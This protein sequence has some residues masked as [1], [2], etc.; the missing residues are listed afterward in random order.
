MF[1]VLDLTADCD[2]ERQ[3][4]EREATSKETIIEISDEEEDDDDDDNDDDVI[5]LTNSSPSRNNLASQVA[6]LDS[7]PATSQLPMIE[8]PRVSTNNPEISSSETASP[9]PQLRR[10]PRN[11]K[12][13][14]RTYAYRLK[15]TGTSGPPRNDQ[16]QQVVTPRTT[17]QEEDLIN[18]LYRKSKEFAMQ[19]Y[20]HHKARF[21]PLLPDHNFFMSRSELS[22]GSPRL[23]GITPF[24][25]IVDQPAG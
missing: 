9:D 21:A 11:A 5:L 3:H 17:H 16:V 25:E 1:T 8:Q 13:H 18:I 15:R 7:S 24:T 20:F 23:G 12:H 6:K 22:C 10:S 14:R 19:F 2:D 4:E